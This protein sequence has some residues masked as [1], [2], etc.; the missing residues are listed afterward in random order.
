[1]LSFCLADDSPT[2]QGFIFALHVYC[3]ALVRYGGPKYISFYLYGV[4]FAFNG[5][6]GSIEY[7]RFDK[8]FFLAN[9]EA[10]LWGIAIS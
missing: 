9:L 10:Y 2:G 5:I 7:G 4:I 1:M 8:Q 3:S 6:Y